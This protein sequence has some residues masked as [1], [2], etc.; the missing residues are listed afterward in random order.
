MN[1]HFPSR[2]SLFLIELMISIFFFIISTTVVLQLF[3]KSYQVS[4]QTIYT[5]NA[6]QCAQ[7]LTELFLGSNA[8]YHFVKAHFSNF[9][10]SHLINELPS[11]LRPTYEQSTT[12]PSHLLL[13]YDKDWHSCT[14]ITDADFY[15]HVLFSEEAAFAYESIYIASDIPFLHNS[16]SFEPFYEL[17]VQKYLPQYSDISI[18]KGV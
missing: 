13:L 14:T 7:N 8:D 4:Q 10:C 12:A 9:D 18:V 11:S 15:V 16:N 6:Y 2:T 3:V 1:N 5:N 17:T